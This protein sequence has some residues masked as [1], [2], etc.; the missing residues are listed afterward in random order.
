MKRI[1]SFLL[2]I[3]LLMSFCSCSFGETP[4]DNGENPGDGL[5]NNV[6]DPVDDPV[7]PLGNKVGDLAYSL[8]LS[9]LTGEGKVS[10]DDY[11]GK[12]VVLNFWGTW[13]GPCKNELPHFNELAVEY[14]DD[15]VFLLVHSV[16]AEGDPLEYVS[17]LFPDSPMIFAR[18]SAIGEYDKYYEL[19]GGDGYYPRTYILDADGVITYA[20]SNALSKNALKELIESALK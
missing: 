7:A 2:M 8:D 18:D 9:L 5:G 16:Y 4:E 15:V 6:D 20:Q 13:C 11:R 1:L 14:S 3:T 19:M 12:V 10:V 17:E